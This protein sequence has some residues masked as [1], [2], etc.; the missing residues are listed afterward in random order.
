MILT[1]SIAPSTWLSVPRKRIEDEERRT[2]NHNPAHY[3]YPIVAR[4]WRSDA[5]N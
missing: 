1:A 2:G 5:T 4:T 3:A